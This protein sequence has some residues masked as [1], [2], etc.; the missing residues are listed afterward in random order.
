MLPLDGSRARGKLDAR[1]GFDC[2]LTPARVLGEDQTREL[3]PRRVSVGVAIH[4]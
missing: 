2:E 1:A 4:L 3:M